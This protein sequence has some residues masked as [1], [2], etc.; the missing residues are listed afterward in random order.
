[1]FGEGLWPSLG[2]VRIT[3]PVYLGFGI[4]NPEQRERMRDGSLETPDSGVTKLQASDNGDFDPPR[5]YP[6]GEGVWYR[7]RVCFEM[8]RFIPE[9]K[10]LGGW[11]GNHD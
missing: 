7:L 4:A 1:M 3:N 9:R 6:G 5:P 8:E 11:W 2:G 10:P